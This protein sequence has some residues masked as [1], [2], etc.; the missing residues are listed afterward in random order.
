MQ[1][2]SFVQKTYNHQNNDDRK[3]LLQCFYG[4]IIDTFKDLYTTLAAIK[5]SRNSIFSLDYYAN[6]RIYIIKNT[7]DVSIKEL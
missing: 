7:P 4:L 1:K 6:F 5:V 3:Y 2:N